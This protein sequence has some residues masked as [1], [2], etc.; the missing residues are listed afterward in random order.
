MC[1]PRQARLNALRGVFHTQ[2]IEEISAKYCE[3]PA[4]CQFAS[5]ACLCY[6]ITHFTLQP[7]LKILPSQYKCM[8]GFYQSF[9]F[10]D[11]GRPTDDFLK[12]LLPSTP[13]HTMEPQYKSAPPLLHIDIRGVL[14][15]V[16][17][18]DINCQLVKTLYRLMRRDTR[19]TP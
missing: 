14:P 2:F 3:N 19:S 5:Q 9:I 17:V 8:I 6:I 12:M 15:M 4:V 10:R 11:I 16:T 13:V 1:S 7:R 18:L